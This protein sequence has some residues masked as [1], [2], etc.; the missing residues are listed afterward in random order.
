MNVTGESTADTSYVAREPIRVAHIMGKMRTGGVES[1]VL[2]YYRHM[3]RSKVQFD[4]VVDEDSPSVPYDEIESL[5]GQVYKIPPYQKPFAYHSALVRL[6][7]RNKYA[8]VHSHINTLSVFALFAAKRA[9]VPVRIAHSHSTAGKGETKRNLLKYGLRPFSRAFPTHYYACSEYAGRWLFGNR[10]YDAGKVVLIKNAI[11]IKRFSFSPKTRREARES[12]G[13]T[14]RFV[15]GH[16]GRFMT[17]KNHSFIVDIFKQILAMEPRAILL[18]AGEG[19]LEQEIR[20][21]VDLLGLTEYVRF[22]GVRDD[23]DKLMMA[24]DAF[25]LPSLYEGLPVV[26]IEAQACGLLMVVSDTVTTEAK[27]NKN[28]IYMPLSAP[29]D[30]WAR[31]TLNGL[32]FDRTAAFGAVAGAGYEID[33]AAKELCERYMSLL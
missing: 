20:E 6:L 14:D 22:L 1:V 23:V 11:D 27:I 13:V 2:N 17:Q 33:G 26:A 21:K 31:K 19:G 32:E 3:D 15:L 18:L 28:L 12:L 8:I 7:R 30:E 9:R 10:L 24:F 25:L 16:T 29:A 5:G 4:F